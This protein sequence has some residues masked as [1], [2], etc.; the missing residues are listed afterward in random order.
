MGAAMVKVQYVAEGGQFNPEHAM[1]NEAVDRMLLNHDHPPIQGAVPVAPAAPVPIVE[2]LTA[3]AATKTVL[4]YCREPGPIDFW[5]WLIEQVNWPTVLSV[6]LRVTIVVIF[7]LGTYTVFNWVVGLCK[8]PPTPDSPR[9]LQ[10]K[11]IEAMRNRIYPNA[12]RN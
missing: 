7:L 12:N 8:R 6:T 4:P 5:W 10:R 9:T 3:A 2:V 1:Q 11:S